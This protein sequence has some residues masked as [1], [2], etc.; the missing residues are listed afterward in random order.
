[1]QSDEYTDY[2]HKSVVIDELIATLSHACEIIAEYR[3]L[4][5]KAG[6]WATNR[7]AVLAGRV[8]GYLARTDSLC[9]VL[10]FAGLET[11]KHLARTLSRSVVRVW[12]QVKR[13]APN[14]F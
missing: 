11:D 13:E 6:E 14:P 1:M 9:Y 12:E 4:I 5:P 2:I 10:Q 8:P 3:A 7:R